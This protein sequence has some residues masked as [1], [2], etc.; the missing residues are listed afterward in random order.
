MLRLIVI[1][2]I[3]VTVTACTTAS[4]YTTLEPELAKQITRI[5]NDSDIYTCQFIAKGNQIYTDKGDLINPAIFLDDVKGNY[6]S[7]NVYTR[8]LI[9]GRPKDNH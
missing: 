4:K 3:V 6:I 5:L 9:N 2:I 1:L 8:S 7:G